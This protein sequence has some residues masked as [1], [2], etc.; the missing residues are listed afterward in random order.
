[1]NYLIRWKC[2]KILSLVRGSGGCWIWA[3]VGVCRRGG[4]GRNRGGRRGSFCGLRFGEGFGGVFGGFG[5]G[6]RRCCWDGGRLEG[7][8]S[9]E[10]RRGAR[11]E[12]NE[13][14][15]ERGAIRA[16]SEPSSRTQPVHVYHHLPPCLFRVC[17]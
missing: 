4:G 8:G 11:S 3:R 6:F 9:S 15:A 1:M 5:R 12:G 2:K 17:S 14:R 7:G 10:E 13:A 16:R